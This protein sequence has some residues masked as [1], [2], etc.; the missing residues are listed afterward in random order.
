M[1]VFQNLIDNGI[2]YGDENSEIE[3][4][5]EKVD[6]VP[7]TDMPGISFKTKGTALMKSLPG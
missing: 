7:E 1:E 2:K 6:R 4:S 3:I 5:I